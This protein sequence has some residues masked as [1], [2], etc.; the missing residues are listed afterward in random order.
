[1]FCPSTDVP[2]QHSIPCP[3]KPP[4]D[5]NGSLR[6]TNKRGVE[7]GKSLAYDHDQ[8]FLMKVVQVIL[9]N[10]RTGIQLQ[11][12]NACRINVPIPL[13]WISSQY[14]SR[15]WQQQNLTCWPVVLHHNHTEPDKKLTENWIRALCSYTLIC[16]FTYMICLFFSTLMFEKPMICPCA[17]ALKESP[18]AL[19]EMGGQRKSS[20]QNWLQYLFYFLLGSCL[21]YFITS[22][23]QT[24]MPNGPSFVYAAR[25]ITFHTEVYLI[26]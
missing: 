6:G 23:S 20:V 13:D 3:P 12:S 15:N 16:S 24:E 9:P 5:F 25:E 11:T 14:P 1:M 4:F 8:E 2:V 17:V 22:Y 26:R 21:E 19:W 7:E 18:L 10:P